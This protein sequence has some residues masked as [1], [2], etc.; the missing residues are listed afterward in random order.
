VEQLGNGGNLAKRWDV[1]WLVTCAL[2][3]TTWCLTAAYQLGPTFDEPGYLDL[4]LR[5]WRSG[6]HRALVA[7]GGTM[8]L[9]VDLFTLPIHVWER[10]QGVPLNPRTDLGRVL[11]VAR[12]SVL[13]F[14]WLLLFYGW[15]TGQAL[16][17]PWGGSL[18]VALLACEPVLLGHACLA[19]TDLALCSCLLALAYHYRAGRDMPGARR[20]MLP[21]FWFGMA[22]LA[23]AS[24]LVF[25]V[26]CLAVLEGEYLWR[27]HRTDWRRYLGPS[28]GQLAFVA[29]GGCVLVFGWCGDSAY[30]A[31]RFQM[32]HSLAGHGNIYLL[33][34]TGP[35]FWYYFPVA[36]SI[37][38]TL[39]VLILAVVLLAVR[40]RALGNWA[41]LTTLSLLAL[42]PACSVQI[43]VRLVLPLVAFGVVG[44]AAGLVQ[45][46]QSLSAKVGRWLLASLGGA[47]VLWSAWASV[48][49]WP[50]GLCYTNELWGGTPEGYR[51]LSDSNYD[52]GQGLPE[53]TR[54]QRQ[55]NLAGMDIWYYGTDPAL[56]RRSL[57][58]LPWNAL[59][60]Q[61][62]E[63]LRQAVHGRF[64]AASTSLVFGSNRDDPAARY[65][66][67]CTPAAR[68]STF[69]I[70]DFTHP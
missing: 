9:A 34:Q 41:I 39:T 42:T 31:L 62:P 8:P 15:R 12:A 29:I 64:F 57:R 6:S 19:T 49:V 67:T 48:S 43:G 68:T 56:F 40:P 44:L 28:L 52:W 60:A 55:Q 51:L 59:A 20:L 18:A 70:Y 63:C 26:L 24:G 69:L 61:G 32:H 38:L 2:A 7:G 13:L 46:W 50:N 25:G 35:G 3:S 10:W 1:L 30:H 11:P 16:A 66:R 21:A 33:G 58:E 54:W 53:L 23:K 36:L 47:A 4:G 5:F 65:L 45:A 27:N 14:W 22:M 37:K 17:G